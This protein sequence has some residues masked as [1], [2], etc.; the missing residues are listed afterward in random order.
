MSS[1]DSSDEEDVGVYYYFRRR[2]QEK[3][4]WVHPYL[5][6]NIRCRLFVAAKELQQTD[7]KQTSHHAFAVISFRE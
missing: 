5:E 1:A 2:K 4:C 3:R 6:K 7:T